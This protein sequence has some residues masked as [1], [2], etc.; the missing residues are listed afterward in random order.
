M[1]RREAGRCGSDDDIG[2]DDHET[3]GN[4]DMADLLTTF[5]P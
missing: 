5:W 1:S 2:Q 4:F 3:T